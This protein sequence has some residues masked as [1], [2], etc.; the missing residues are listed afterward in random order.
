MILAN[1]GGNGE[2][3]KA[4]PCGSKNNHT[5]KRR[6]RDVLLKMRKYDTG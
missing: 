4:R 1:T 3:K 6:Y 2:K 5:D